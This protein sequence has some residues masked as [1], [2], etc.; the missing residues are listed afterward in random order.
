MP[1]R[2]SLDV[3]AL[4]MKV[5]RTLLTAIRSLRRNILRSVLTCLG[6]IIGIASVIALMEIGRGATVAIQTAVAKFGANIVIIIPGETTS[7]GVS[8][9]S[10]TRITLTPEDCDAIREEC[11]AVRKAAP[12]VGARLQLVYGNRNWQPNNIYGTTPEYLDVGNWQISEGQ[13]FTDH[14]VQSVAQVC[15]IG[16]TLV[17]ELFDG[18]DPIGKSIRVRNTNLHVVGVLVGKGAVM[19]GTDQDDVLIAPWTTVKFRL[20]SSMLGLTN[21]SAAAAAGSSLTAMNTL[22]NLYPSASIDPYPVLSASQAADTPQPVRFQNVDSIFVSVRSSAEIES[23]IHQVTEML[24]ERHRLGE[25][26]PNDFQ[27]LNISE[28][29]KAFTSTTEILTHLLMSVAAISLMVGG[30]GIMNIML[31]TVTERTREIGLRMAVGARQKDILQ[32]FLVEAVALCLLGGLIGVA[33]GRGLSLL[34]QLL[35]HWPIAMSLPAIL[36]ALAVSGGVG[37]VFG[38]YPA[39]KASRLDPIDALRF[40]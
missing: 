27:V 15:L 12:N 7:S 20:S 17:R 23:A 35:L 18:D 25:D 34:V 2:L 31:V 10:G 36:I 33:C 40:E 5:R 32:Q 11:P 26:Q 37:M 30:V 38:Y 14:D 8:F 3:T 28:F 13:P 29:V 6:I 21:Q 24:R 16:Q 22:S 9:G 4:T 19:G 1:A 39:W